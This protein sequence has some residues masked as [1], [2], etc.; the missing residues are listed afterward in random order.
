MSLGDVGSVVGGFLG[1]SSGASSGPAS[2]GSVYPNTFQNSQTYQNLVGNNTTNANIA[3]NLNQSATNTYNNAYSN[4]YSG[5]LQQGA[6]T[7]GTGLQNVGTTGLNNSSALSSSANSLLPYIQQVMQQ[8]LDPQNALFNRQQQQ[9]RDQSNVTNAQQGLT[10]PYAAGVT[11]QNL[12]NFD[13]DWQNN[14]LQRAIS[15]LSAGGT[16]IN[17]AGS[18]FNTAGQIGGQAGQDIYAGA[19]LPYNAANSITNNQT[20]DINNLIGSLGGINNIDSQTMSS[21]LQYLA[22]SSN[23][24]IAQNSASANSASS[25]AAGGSNLGGIIGDAATKYGPAI[26]A[27][28]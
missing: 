23:Y 5:A 21:L 7:A 27:A 13:I 25:G 18:G 6:G 1:G 3:Q 9:V 28:L 16:A 20:T 4:P 24:G 15:G 11:N 14:A 2:V 26:L 19:G 22:Q 12:N 8:G 17:Q 10:G